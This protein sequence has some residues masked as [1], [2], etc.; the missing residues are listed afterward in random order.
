MSHRFSI[1]VGHDSDNIALHFNPRFTQSGDSR[2]IICNSNLGGWGDEHREPCFPFEYGQ[3]FKVTRQLL[4]HHM[5][6][7]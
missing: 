1:N 2:V 3:E 7:I 4:I 6:N 5:K